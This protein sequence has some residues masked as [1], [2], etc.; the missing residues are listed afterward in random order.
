MPILSDCMGHIIIS[1]FHTGF[2]VGGGECFVMLLSR[3][4]NMPRGV[5]YT[6]ATLGGSGGHAPPGFFF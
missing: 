5:S 6:H 4:C 1:G 3:M 2:C